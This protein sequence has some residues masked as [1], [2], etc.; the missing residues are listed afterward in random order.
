MVSIIILLTTKKLDECLRFFD[1]LAGWFR[2]KCIFAPLFA[3]GVA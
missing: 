3:A 2:K 1:R